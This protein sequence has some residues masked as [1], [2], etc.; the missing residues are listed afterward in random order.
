MVGLVSALTYAW[1]KYE[2]VFLYDDYQSGYAL[3]ELWRI[4]DAPPSRHNEC[5]AASF[6]LYP[7]SGD[8]PFGAPGR[9]GFVAGC[10][11]GF[12]GIASSGWN[13]RSRIQPIM[14]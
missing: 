12:A 1:W 8:H 13:L 11:D 2:K 7:T 6:K 10:E 9:L 5:A 4:D 3:G 14:D